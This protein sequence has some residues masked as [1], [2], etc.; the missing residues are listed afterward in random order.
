V[1]GHDAE[2][3]VEVIRDFPAWQFAA[4][5]SRLNFDNLNLSGQMIFELQRREDLDQLIE[6]SK[7]HPVLIF[8]HSTQCSVSDAAYDEFLKFT[9]DAAEVP[10]GVVLVVE[11]RDI[12]DDIAARFGVRHQSPQA[13]VIEEGRPKWNA[14]HWSI[15]A[16]ALDRAVKG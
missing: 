1:R 9:A 4:P 6:Q 16:D 7:S 14:S 3:E 10:C 8:K 11:N 15:T 13:I 12:S 2:K 5:R